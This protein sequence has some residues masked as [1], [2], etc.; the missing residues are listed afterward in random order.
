MDEATSALDT[1]S[2]GIVQ[3]A[4]KNASKGRTTVVIAHRLSTIR[5]ADNI[6][7]M[8][9]GRIV[10][11]GSHNVLLDQGGAYCRL[12]SSQ[13]VSSNEE[14]N[15]L[16]TAEVSSVYSESYWDE[17]LHNGDCDGRALVSDSESTLVPLVELKDAKADDDMPQKQSVQGTETTTGTLRKW[18]RAR[19]SKSKTSA[20][21][22][23]SYSF[24][25]LVKLIASL[26]KPEWKEMCIA[27][28]AC[29]IGGSGFPTQSVFFA[30][31]IDTLSR[32]MD[33]TTIPDIKHRSSFWSLM[34]LMLGLVQLLA[35][36]TQGVLFGRCSERL[37]HRARDLAFKAYL[38]QDMEFFDRDENATGALTSFLSTQ[39]THLAGL[40]GATLGVI[41]MVVTTI[42]TAICLALAI[43]WKLALVCIST[44]PILLACGFF[45]FWMLAHYQ[46]RAQVAYQQSAAIASE[47]I[48]AIRTIAAL[49][50]EHEVSRQYTESLTKQRKSSLRSIL[51]SSLLYAASQSLTFGAF[52]LGFWYGGDLIAKREYTQFQLF[53]VFSAV[54]LG[55]QSAGTLLSFAPDVGRAAS[56]SADLK[57]LFD[58][59]STIEKDCSRKN[60]ADH[61]RERTTDVTAG[62]V[63]LRD[64]HFCY[65]SRPHQL[66]LKGIDIKIRPGQFVAFVGASGSGKST[67]IALLERFYDPSWGSVLID[68][69]PLTEM[70][71]ADY[72]STVALVSQEPNLYSGTIRDNILLGAVSDKPVSDAEIE[73]A[74]RA[75]NIWD[76][77]SSLPDGLNSAT[78]PRGVLLSGGQKQRIAIARAL[79][80]KPRILLLDEATSALDG[81]SEK[82]VQD[83][84][85]KAAEGRTTIAVAH[86]LSTV[87]QADCIYVFEHSVVVESGDHAALMRKNGRYAELARLQRLDK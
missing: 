28:L 52:A 69:Q 77:V 11:Q 87:H 85:D 37:I 44:I 60:E 80:R 63:E 26:N 27:I 39:T 12:V 45:R 38:R 29:V 8:Q 51:K 65:P 20:A 76:Y 3:L 13:A 21:K 78:G 16:P 71:L 79:I 22:Q 33:N 25:P 64:V 86:R 31:L 50:M 81:E 70:D 40:S 84:L 6:V 72:R 41:I 68:G 61:D 2:E 42:V 34:Y 17:T 19:K 75:A 30:K 24:W 43:G 59:P 15:D 32:P 73:S 57:A 62:A 47:S 4:L 46:L 82:V 36:A 66:V 48:T 7:V 58:R 18:I 9:Q 5:D 23:K 35:L 55:S 49:T 14:P 83:A 1:K 54:I 53:V 74:C 10:E 67:A 56:A